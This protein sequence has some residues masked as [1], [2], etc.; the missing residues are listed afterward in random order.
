MAVFLPARAGRAPL[1]ASLHAGET[2]AESE[3][4][5]R[6]AEQRTRTDGSVP[7]GHEAQ[8]PRALTGRVDSIEVYEIIMQDTFGD[9]RIF[10]FL[11]NYIEHHAL[12]KTPDEKK[13]DSS[14]WAF[15]FLFDIWS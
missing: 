9:A 11:N 6:P 1:P 10:S 13:P 7:P 8:S 2:R 5:R 15:F 3:G 4:G 14:V 12:K